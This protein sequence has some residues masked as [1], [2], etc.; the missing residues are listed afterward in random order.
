MEI[1][2][3]PPLAVIFSLASRDVGVDQLQ[4]RATLPLLKQD[5]ELRIGAA[6]RELRRPPGLQDSTVRFNLERPAGDIAIPGAEDPIYAG[7]YLCGAAGELTVRFALQP[8]IED[9]CSRYPRE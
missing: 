2:F 4:L 8:G 1:K 5:L 3:L 9:I 7:F 6:L